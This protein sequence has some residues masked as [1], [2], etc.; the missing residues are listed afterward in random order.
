MVSVVDEHLRDQLSRELYLKRKIVVGDVKGRL[1]TTIDEDEDDLLDLG[2]LV[3]GLPAPS[4]DKHKWWLN[5]GLHAKSLVQAPANSVI[6]SHRP[7]NP[8][9]ETSEPD[10]VGVGSRTPPVD[11]VGRTGQ[12]SLNAVRKPV[13]K[14]PPPLDPSTG[15]TIP[16]SGDATQL[17]RKPL[18][19]GSP[20]ASI[21][22]ESSRKDGK[23][24]V[25]R[26][27]VDLSQGKH[28]SLDGQPPT[29]YSGST[30]SV[31]DAQSGRNIYPPPPRRASTMGSYRSGDSLVNVT[32]L[33]TEALPELPPRPTVAE[34][35]DAEAEPLQLDAWQPLR[36]L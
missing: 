19:R 30:A 1:S 28:N 10:W 16:R 20:A 4:S 34:L 13:R 3:P 12:P 36:P 35:M 33:T 31:R 9:R 5:D 29:I 23:P 14:L 32:R 6:N 11:I 15:P 26:K 18:P 17:A 24:P 8:F 2:P 7:T 25:P 27:P 21:K 22:S